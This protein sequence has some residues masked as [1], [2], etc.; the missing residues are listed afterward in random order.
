MKLLFTFLLSVQFL[1]AQVWI[2]LADYPG[3]KRDD[4]VAVV[5][6]NKAYVGTGLV[7]WALTLDFWVM[8]LSNYTWSYGKAMPP[9]TNRQYACAFAGNNCFYVFGGDAAGGGANNKLF[10]YD[11]LSDSWSSVTSKPGSGLIGAAC[12]NFGDKVIISGG[13]FQNNKASAEVWEYTKSTDTWLQKNNYPFPGRFRPSAT[14]LNNAGY[15]IFGKDTGG[16]FRKKFYKYT[17]VTDS[18]TKIMDFPGTKGRAYSSLNVAHG[19]LT[20]FG[21]VDTLDNFYKDIWYFNE[22]TT[23][24]IQGPDIPAAGRK[25]GMS[26]AYGED[27]FYTCGIAG[28][29]RVTETW[30]TDVPVG[31][32]KENKESVFFVYPNPAN[33]KVHISLPSKT[34]FSLTCSYEDV[35]GRSLGIIDLNAQ[36]EIDLNNLKT[37]IY[38]LKFYAENELIEIKKI[39]KN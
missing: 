3:L 33:E 16:A 17:P 2:P 29:S 28:G 9:N 11:V 37:G 39:V 1:S 35:L 15:L 8:D 23:S 21:G 32:K 12:M 22:A 38:F 26:W 36:T 6:G 34:F 13:K 4:G 14:V 5:V 19:K 18:W 30:K 25:G 27:L 31:I 24:W 10:K 7:E 20:L